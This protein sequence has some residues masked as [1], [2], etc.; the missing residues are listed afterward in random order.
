MKNKFRQEFK[1]ALD[2][3]SLKQY[4]VIKNKAIVQTI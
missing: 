2:K 4:N 3:L 1:R